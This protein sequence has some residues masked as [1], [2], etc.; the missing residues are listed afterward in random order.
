[1]LPIVAGFVDDADGACCVD[2]AS[3]SNARSPNRDDAGTMHRTLLHGH[4]N[5]LTRVLTHAGGF[6]LRLANLIGI[7]TPRGL[8][9]RLATVMAT[10][11]AGRTC[12]RGNNH[13]CGHAEQREGRHARGR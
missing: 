10:H 12:S 8:E 5:I 3:C 9:G 1:M 13:A 7:G 4:T 11:C 2:V 6:N